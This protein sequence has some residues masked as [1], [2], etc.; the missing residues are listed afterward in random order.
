MAQSPSL[1]KKTRERIALQNKSFRREAGV[2]PGAEECMGDEAGETD[3]VM[4][5]SR[6]VCTCVG[7]HR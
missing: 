4:H 3:C 2:D 7:T 6:T 5:S 1:Q